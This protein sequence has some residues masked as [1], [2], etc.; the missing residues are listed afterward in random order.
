MEHIRY[1]IWDTDNHPL[2]NLICKIYKSQE[3]A[4]KF[5]KK[6]NK[7]SFIIKSDDKVGGGQLG[8]H[9]EWDTSPEFRCTRM[10]FR[11]RPTK[12]YIMHFHEEDRTIHDYYLYENLGH[13]I[14]MAKYLYDMLEGYMIEDSKSDETYDNVEDFIRDLKKNNEADFYGGYFDLA[15]IDVS[16]THKFNENVRNSITVIYN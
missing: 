12:L 13:V 3:H 7:K 5:L 15:I 11:K 16:N 6:H 14:E 9:S 4:I 2:E 1:I 10:V 8:D